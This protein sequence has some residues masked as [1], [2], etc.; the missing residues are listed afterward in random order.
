MKARILVKLGAFLAVAGLL[1]VMELG[2][3]TGPHVGSTHTYYAVFGGADGVSGLRDG[4]PV[5]VSGVAVGKVASVEL[6]DATHAKVA[7]TANGNQKITSHTWALV[8]YANL[9]GQRYLALSQAGSA[10]GK[11]LAPG[12]TIPDARTEPALSLTDLFN[13]FRPLFSALTPQQV[14]ALSQDIIGVLQGQTGRI[15]D[16]IAQTADLTSNLADRNQ[17]FTQVVDSLSTLLGAVAKHDNQLAQVV[18]TLH[19][20][21]SQLHADGPAILDSLGSVDALTGSVAGLLGKLEDH[22][23]PA[24]L[25]D[26]ASVTG[27]LAKSTDT[28]KTLV[29]GFV[30]AFGTFARVSQNGNWINVYAC[31]VYA[32]TLGTVS[33]TSKQ[34]L[35]ALLSLIKSPLAGSISDLTGGI[36]DGL[37]L[38]GAALPLPL[39]LPNGR[40][41]GSSAQTKVCS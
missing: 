36:I 40:V 13:G 9:L 8:R 32:R 17:T 15:E 35:N 11:V 19:E 25:S 14:N 20:L 2:T 41:G 7:F 3:L 21:T 22:N 6:V 5:R 28:V 33:I 26:A 39:K 1:A 24:D 12:A 38:G 16:L 27:V 29:D 18:T 30:Q 4:N 10:P 31:N 23:L 34:G 37:G